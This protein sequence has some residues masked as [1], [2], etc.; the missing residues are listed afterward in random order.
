MSRYE[1]MRGTDEP[2]D[3]TVMLD[4]RP[5]EALT[6]CALDIRGGLSASTW[7]NRAPVLE[8]ALNTFFEPAGQTRIPILFVHEDLGRAH[9][10]ARLEAGDATVKRQGTHDASYLV[11][12]PTRAT[13]IDRMLN[14]GRMTCDRYGELLRPGTPN[15]FVRAGYSPELARAANRVARADAERRGV[16]FEGADT[17][18]QFRVDLKPYAPP[19]TDDPRLRDRVHRALSKH[20]REVSVLRAKQTQD[21]L[22]CRP[23]EAVEMTFESLTLGAQRLGERRFGR[24]L[25]IKDKPS[26][27]DLVKPATLSEQGMELLHGTWIDDERKARDPNGWGLADYER[28]CFAGNP[29]ALAAPVFLNTRNEALLTG[30]AQKRHFRPAM[31]KAG[32][33]YQGEPVA[34]GLGRHDGVT[35]ALAKIDG[36]DVP[37]TM[38]EALRAD[39]VFLLQWRSKR[40]LQTYGASALEAAR[41]RRMAEFQDRFGS[42]AATGRLPRHVEE[43]DPACL[44]DAFGED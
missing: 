12:H 10:R 15:P 18:R 28:E 33:R 17:G 7:A 32:I 20:C 34:M 8:E 41:F 22:K 30:T 42:P 29:A 19:R 23:S 35:T 25:I 36:L 21:D 9:I 1:V 37:E 4:G 6:I 44:A 27:D 11:S 24:Y 39:L 43:D 5:H 38:K 16:P 31:I 40:W 13:R 14:L 26:G 3:G 2:L